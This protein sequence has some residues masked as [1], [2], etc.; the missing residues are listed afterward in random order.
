MHKIN[1]NTS[2]NRLHL[3]FYLQLTNC[4]DAERGTEIK[5]GR[6]M[7]VLQILVRKFPTY[8]STTKVKFQLD[9]SFEPNG[10]EESENLSNIPVISSKVQIYRE[11]QSCY[12]HDLL[13]PSEHPHMWHCAILLWNCGV[14]PARSPLLENG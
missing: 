8:S 9:S 6:Q 4:R 5:G 12:R 14:D 2:E 3:C 11:F 10:G 7:L 13:V 1:K